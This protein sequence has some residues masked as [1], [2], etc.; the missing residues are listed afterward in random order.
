MTGEQFLDILCGQ[1][2]LAGCILAATDARWVKLT[3]SVPSSAVLR[4]RFR[5]ALVGGAIGDAMGRPN[6]GQSTEVARERKI[7]E[8]RPWQGWTAGPKGTITDD[9][10]MTMWV[11]GWLPDGI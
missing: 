5:G 10:Q 1:S 8:Y 2:D 4:D 11:A 6:E 9:T 3:L 7:R